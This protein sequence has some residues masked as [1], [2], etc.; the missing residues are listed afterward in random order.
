MVGRARY[1]DIPRGDIIG[2]SVANGL[3]DE[4]PKLITEQGDLTE[5]N[6][7][8]VWN[9]KIRP[10]PDEASAVFKPNGDDPR[11]PISVELRTSKDGAPE[12]VISAK[13]SDFQLQLLPG[14][15]LMAMTF[16]HIEFRTV[17]GAKPEVDVQF[18][19]MKFLGILEFGVFLLVLASLSRWSS[20]R[21]AASRCFRSPSA[22]RCSRFIQR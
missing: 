22:S 8:Y 15:P 17:T 7:R 16:R 5:Q 21:T 9:P 20:C 6:V 3:L 1:A 12:S 2:D 13:L 4:A 18:D 14:E 19:D 10:W 11:L